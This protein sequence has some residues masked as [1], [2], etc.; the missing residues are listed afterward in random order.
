[1]RWFPK[2]RSVMWGVPITMTVV[3]IR[4]ALF[5]ESTMYRLGLRVLRWACRASCKSHALQRNC[6]LGFRV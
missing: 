2:I 5:R 3:D 6:E 4:V 1:M